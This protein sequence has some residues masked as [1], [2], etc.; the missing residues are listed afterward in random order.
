LL[1]LGGGQAGEVGVGKEKVREREPGPPSLCFTNTFSLSLSLFS[2]LLLLFGF[3]ETAS[4]YVA[5]DGLV[6]TIFLLQPYEH[7]NDTCTLQCLASLFLYNKLKHI[8]ID[9]PKRKTADGGADQWQRAY[10]ACVRLWVQPPAPSPCSSP[11]LGMN[12]EPRAC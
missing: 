4:H 2:F 7:W 6:L 10:L 8:T 9:D 3:F 11:T 5:Q 12:P 1:G